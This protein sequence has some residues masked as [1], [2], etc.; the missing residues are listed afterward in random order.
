[1]GRMLRAIK[2]M[3]EGPRLDNEERQHEYV[4]RTI[5]QSLQRGRFIT[6]SDVERR[7]KALADHV[8]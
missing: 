6:S 8:F 3:L 1:M 7:R 4:R 2:L 5:T